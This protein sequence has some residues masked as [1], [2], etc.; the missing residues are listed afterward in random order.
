MSSVK[1]EHCGG[2]CVTSYEHAIGRHRF[3]DQ[4][5]EGLRVCNIAA[6]LVFLLPARSDG[7]YAGVQEEVCTDFLKQYHMECPLF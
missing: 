5:R 6:R 2:T 7:I 3:S 1:Q 4:I